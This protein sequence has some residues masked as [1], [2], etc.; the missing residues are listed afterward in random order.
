MRLGLLVG[1]RSQSLRLH[2]VRDREIEMY[3]IEISLYW[4]GPMVDELGEGYKSLPPS[5]SLS[6]SLSLGFG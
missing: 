2:N 1:S 4:V 6:L 3:V 5:L